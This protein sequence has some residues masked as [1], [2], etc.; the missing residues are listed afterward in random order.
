MLIMSY[1]MHMCSNPE[2]VFQR[3]TRWLV[4]TVSLSD[5]CCFN[6]VTSLEKTFATLGLP[7]RKVI[8][9]ALND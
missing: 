9:K 4:V 5:A 7:N 3:F 8:E 2:I 1:N 6:F